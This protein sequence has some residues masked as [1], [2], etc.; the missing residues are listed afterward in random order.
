[1]PARRHLI[2]VLA[3]LCL[4]SSIAFAQLSY[5]TTFSTNVDGN[6]GGLA[7]AD[8]NRDGKPIW[9]CSAVLRLLFS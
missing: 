1:M 2:Q 7:A 9:P 3:L 5:T 4:G 8:F 6:P